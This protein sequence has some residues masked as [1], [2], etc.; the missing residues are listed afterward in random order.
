MMTASS[1]SL[2]GSDAGWPA[3]RLERPSR[4]SADFDGLPAAALM[5]GASK[6]CD[7]HGPCV[8]PPAGRPVL[9]TPQ[10]RP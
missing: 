7:A 1:G 6:A 9:A 5:P 2:Q 10:G 8:K 4:V 3:K